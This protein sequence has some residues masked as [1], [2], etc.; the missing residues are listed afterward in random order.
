MFVRR[1]RLGLLILA[2]AC[3][4][5]G[6]AAFAQ[7]APRFVRVPVYFVTDRNLHSTDAHSGPE[8]GPQR[9]YVGDCKHDPFMGNGYC[10]LENTAAKKLTPELIALG[11][12]AAEE[13]EIEGSRKLQLIEAASFPEIQ[14]KFC[15][16]LLEDA[17]KSSHKDIILFAHGYKNSFNSALHTAAR[18]SYSFEE[19]AIL[20]SWPSVAKLRSYTADENNNEWSQEHYNDLI[21]KLEELC[22]KNTDVHMRIFAHSLGT[23]LAIRATPIIRLKKCISEVALVCPDIDQ[24]LVKHYARRYLSAEGTCMLRMYMSQADKA[25]VFSQMMHGGYNRLGECADSITAFAS[26]L[27]PSAK[28]QTDD[29]LN[30]AEEARFSSL[31]EKTK[32]R[33]QTID[34]TELDSGLIGHKIPTDLMY[35]MSYTNAPGEGLKLEHESSGERNKYSRLLSTLTRHRQDSVMPKDTCLK[36]TKADSNPNRKVAGK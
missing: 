33:M 5:Y 20:Y 13:K 34:F 4:L 11:W 36:V 23:R 2:F 8:F 15:E 21:E 1:F 29:Q 3:L 30:K 32:K 14:D 26:S 27:I 12:A 16:K 7:E 19:P 10:V 31:V 35:S 25:L 17:R 22:D 28:A 9:K 24:G 18:F 6:S